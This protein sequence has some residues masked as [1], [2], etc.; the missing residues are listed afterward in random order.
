[1]VRRSHAQPDHC[2]EPR[3]LPHVS[4]TPVVEPPA[5]VRG[6]RRWRRTSDRR[7]HE[8]AVACASANCAEA[9]RTYAPRR[10]LL[11]IGNVT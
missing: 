9:D 8:R 2:A 1:M 10:V 7:V 3:E 4:S 11:E 5:C 6:R